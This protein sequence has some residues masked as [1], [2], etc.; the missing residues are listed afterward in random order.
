MQ[1][2]VWSAFKPRITRPKR[3]IVVI[4][5]HSA[6]HQPTFLCKLFQ[7]LGLYVHT[8]HFILDTLYFTCTPL[9]DAGTLA[10]ALQGINLCNILHKYLCAISFTNIYVQY[11]GY[12][13]D[14]VLHG[15]QDI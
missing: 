4:I 6:L 1:K 14:A 9:Y 11:F 10:D 12:H 2:A 13:L 3:Q 15:R 5:V 7:L 8:V